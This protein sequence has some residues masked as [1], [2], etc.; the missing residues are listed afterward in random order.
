M[1]IHLHIEKKHFIVLLAIIILCF[2]A[3]LVFGGHGDGNPGSWTVSG[4]F[5]YL[6]QIAKNDAKTSVDAD[7]NGIIDSADACNNGDSVCDV[8]TIVLAPQA[9][10]PGSPATGQI[11]LRS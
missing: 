11:W 1:D 4:G 10:D 7:N 2:S 3:I 8:A 5:H 6:Q 9:A